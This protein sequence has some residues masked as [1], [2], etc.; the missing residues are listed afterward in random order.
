[1]YN[2]L[3]IW[4]ERSAVSVLFKVSYVGFEPAFLFYQ[5]VI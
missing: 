5:Q 4:G 2:Y 1:M 3:H